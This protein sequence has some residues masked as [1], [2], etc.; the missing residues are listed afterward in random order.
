MLRR[1]TRLMAL[2]VALIALFAVGAA[3]ASAAPAWVSPAPTVAGGHT[4]TAPGYNSVQAA[5]NSN[6]ESINIC[7]GTYT[8]EVSIKHGSVKLTAVNG[9]G[10]ATIVMPASAP[11]TGNTCDASGQKDELSLCTSGTVKLTG[12]S[13]EALVPLAECVAP[14]NL[15]GIYLGGGGTLKAT[16]V[17]VNGASTTLAGYKG[18]QDGIAINIE[19]GS[20]VLKKVTA[21]GYQK[22]G[23]TADGSDASLTMS[24][25]TVT[26]EG[27]S[28]EIGQNGIQV[29]YGAK[30]VIKTTKVTDNECELANVCGAN[31]EQATGVLFY[32]AAPGSSL[33]S[34]KIEDNDGGVYYASGSSTL[35]ATP[36][37]TFLKDFLT[38]NRYEGADL[39]EGNSTLKSVTINGTGLRGIQFYQ[40]EKQ[41]SAIVASAVSTKISGQSEA[42]IKVESDKSALD[43]T[44]S[45][46]TFT[47]GSAAAPVLINESN[48]FTVT[49]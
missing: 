5:I 32:E 10:T 27:P 7:S 48:D 29:A 38:S 34:S 40:D 37:V 45:E 14:S 19:E 1:A 12:L 9:A 41:K 17:S 46:F 11:P 47:N 21:K 39:E 43:P 25:S 4:C 28:P 22:N 8:E 36:E 6:V 3:S 15:N 23:P 30:G 31:G 24:S 42:S 33:T 35:A 44:G 2:C 49:F 18:C 13:V 16:N 26:G 20:A